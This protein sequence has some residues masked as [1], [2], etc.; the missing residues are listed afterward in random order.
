MKNTFL[1]IKRLEEIE[2]QAAGKTDR[3]GRPYP[4]ALL[5]KPEELRSILSE[6]IQHRTMKDP[7]VRRVHSERDVIA[8]ALRYVKEQYGEAVTCLV[9]RHPKTNLV[10]LLT[11]LGTQTRLGQT[12]HE[13]YRVLEAMLGD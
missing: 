10:W 7:N 3:D 2:R 1:T 4:S 12:W 8:L 11:S 6:L 13:S 9:S 5:M